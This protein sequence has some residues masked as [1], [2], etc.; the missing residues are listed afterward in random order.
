VTYPLP[1]YRFEVS[2]HPSDA[3]LPPQA[4]NFPRIVAAGAF[5]D[6]TGLSGELEVIAQPEGGRNGFVH[7]LPV[8]YSWGRITLKRGIARDLSLWDW[9][10]D[11]LTGSL[12]AR[13]D[14]AILLYT[15]ANQVA[16]TWEFRAGLAAKWVGPNLSGS[17]AAI[18]I[19]TLEIAH[20]GLE[21]ILN[22]EGG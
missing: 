18:A 12:G 13:R 2:L 6:V 7:Q 3:Y 14:G 8:R 21:Q 19:E 1:N 4:P 16:V 11:G 20:E 5:S 22:L 10:H 15:P 9:F 17:Q